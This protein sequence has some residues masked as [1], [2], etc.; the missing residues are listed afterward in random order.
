[1][2]V[3]PCTM[4]NHTAY[5]VDF[6]IHWTGKIGNHMILIFPGIEMYAV[7]TLG[8]QIDGGCTKQVKRRDINF[9][10]QHWINLIQ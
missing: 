1:M 6:K 9:M 7:G 8:K 3:F 4:T 5:L 10:F 2:P